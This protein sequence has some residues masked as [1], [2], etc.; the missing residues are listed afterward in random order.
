[1]ERENQAN[2]GKISDWLAERHYFGRFYQSQGLNKDGRFTNDCGPASLSMVVNMLLFQAN[3]VTESLNKDTVI[4]SSGMFLWDRIP[5]WVPKFGGATAPWGLVKAFNRWSEEL[6]LYWRA[7]RHSRARRAHIVENLITGKP[8]TALK[9]WKTG[10]AHWINL[11]KYSGEKDRVYFL[12]PNPYLE[13]L[14]EERRLQSQTW[15]EFDADWSRQVW[16]SR[17]LGIRNEIITYSK[18][19]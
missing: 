7:E 16:W 2:S 15:V 9:I 18:I 3:P 13:N 4:H 8:V 11:V 10:G 14:P 12:D 19:L 17:L 6:G 1:M 5:S